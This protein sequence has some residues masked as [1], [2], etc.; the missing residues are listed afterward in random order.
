MR[1][2]TAVAHGRSTQFSGQGRRRLQPLVSRR[3]HMPCEISVAQKSDKSYDH[4]RR[5]EKK[6]APGGNERQGEHQ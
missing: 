5:E 2:A 4:E 1:S 6:L 3:V